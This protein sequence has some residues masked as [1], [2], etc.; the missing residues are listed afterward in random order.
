[1]IPK[2]Q[3]ILNTLN[4][5]TLLFRANQQKIPKLFDEELHTLTVTKEHLEVGNITIPIFI[6]TLN[7]LHTKGY[8]FA[9]SIFE[10]EYHAKI[11]ESASEELQTEVL[12]ALKEK[13][14]EE[15]PLEVKIMFAEALEKMAPPGANFKIDRKVIAEDKIKF[16]DFL[17]E[18]QALR[19]GHKDT[20]VS[21][22]ILLPFRDTQKLLDE[23]NRGESFDDIQDSGIWYDPIKYEFHVG[24]KIIPTSYQGK[25]NVEHEVN[26]DASVIFQIS[27]F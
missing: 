14:I 11:R 13:G 20:D 16:K 17:D 9:V 10:H 19:A 27:V 23:M 3:N 26:G 6:N 21:V 7:T 15:I 18:T 4:L 8:L 2:D 5:L 22:I 25:A 12:E 1:M 24:D